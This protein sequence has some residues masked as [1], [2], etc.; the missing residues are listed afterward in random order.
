M[1]R[2]TD[3][4]IRRLDNWIPLFLLVLSTVMVFIPLLVQ[5]HP[6]AA[7]FVTPLIHSVF[8]IS[9]IVYAAVLGG[10]SRLRQVSIR[11]PVLVVA[12]ALLGIVIYT[13]FWVADIKLYSAIKLGD[14]TLYMGLSFF[15]G[16]IFDRGDPE[17]IQ[18]TL[19]AVFA[20]VVLVIPLIA[21][22][23]HY[24]IPDYYFRTIIGGLVS[25]PDLTTSVSTAF[26]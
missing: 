22:L 19:I 1:P 16:F 3:A 14:L 9:L 17:L 21:F 25:F 23:F 4:A 7:L 13:K 26:H 10:W 11:R 6:K 8:Q 20:S 12:A 15:V 18:R 2:L 24:K 5:I